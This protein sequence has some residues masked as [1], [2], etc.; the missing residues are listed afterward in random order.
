MVTFFLY[1]GSSS[2]WDNAIGKGKKAER[3]VVAA[4]WQEARGD[5]GVQA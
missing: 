4:I 1:T 3:T 5:T 2:R